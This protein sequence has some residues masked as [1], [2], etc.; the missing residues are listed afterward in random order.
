MLHWTTRVLGMDC[1]NRPIPLPHDPGLR[2]RPQQFDTVTPLEFEGVRPLPSG[3]TLT[4]GVCNGEVHIL[5][6]PGLESVKV[7]VRLGKPLNRERTPLNYMRRFTAVGNE[8]EIL[9]KLPEETHPVIDIY[10]PLNTNLNLQLG[11]AK[12][13]VKSVRGNK[14]ISV[15]KGTARLYVTD[16]PQEYSRITVNV[17]M[18]SFSDLRPGGTENHQ[19]PLH[20]EFS[21]TGSATVDLQVAMGKAEIS[22]E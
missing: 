22:L 8:A 6:A 3:S 14:Q 17:A 11:K 21:G 2:L 7:S 5:S 19:V 10:V 20:R 9:W 18:G 16:E 15:G 1:D 12:L 4:L 13:E